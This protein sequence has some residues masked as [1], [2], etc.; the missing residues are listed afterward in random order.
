[1]S[2]F[3][4]PSFAAP[5]TFSATSGTMI[6]SLSRH[7]LFMI[8]TAPRHSRAAWGAAHVCWAW[9]PPLEDGHVDRAEYLP[10]PVLRGAQ[11]VRRH[12]FRSVL[13]HVLRHVFHVFV[14]LVSPKGKR[15]GMAGAH[16]ARAPPRK[17]AM[18]GACHEK[19]SGLP[20]F[21]A[22]K[23]SSATSYATTF[24]CYVH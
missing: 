23:T 4:L 14:L 6:G 12:V 13:R 16:W 9:V 17:M 8:S 5:T 24:T 19:H 3:P 15:G 18:N 20:F 21:A 2:T 1:M 22:P 11:L 7:P 10:A